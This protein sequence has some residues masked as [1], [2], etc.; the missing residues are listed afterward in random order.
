MR[1]PSI[2]AFAAICAGAMVSVWQ[3]ATETEVYAAS[4]A[5]SIATIVCAD[6]FGPLGANRAGWCSR[7]TCL[8]LAIPLH[9]SALVAAPV[10][11]YLA[12]ARAGSHPS[13]RAY[14]WRAGI[15]IAGVAVCAIGLSRLSTFMIAAG[16]RARDRAAPSFLCAASG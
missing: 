1:G 6:Q 7:R 11:I 14:D 13:R 16:V 3:N 8:A 5:L 10:A 9:A 2:T 12:T 4:L 15:A